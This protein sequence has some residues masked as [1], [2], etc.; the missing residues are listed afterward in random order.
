M[1]TPAHAPPPPA[2]RAPDLRLAT[3]VELDAGR[4]ADLGVDGVLLDVDETLVPA[5]VHEPSAAVGEWVAQVRARGLRVAGVSNGAPKR[6]ADVARAVGIPAVSLAGK[7]WPGTFRR[8][9]ARLELPPHRVAM[10]GDQWFTDVLGAYLAGL[11]TVQVTPLSDGGLPH[12]RLLRRVERRL[13]RRRTHA[14]GAT[15]EGR[16][17]DGVAQR[18]G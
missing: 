8:A 5:G 1:T 10:V 11:R 17:A 3:L 16:S 4:L 15:D 9:A 12:T 18:R 14:L 7:P 6:V 13:E 2:R